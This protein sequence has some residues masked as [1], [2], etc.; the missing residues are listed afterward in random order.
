MQFTRYA[1]KPEGGRLWLVNPE[2]E[3]V[4]DLR[5]MQLL[6]FGNTISIEGG[7]FNDLLGEP[8]NGENASLPWALSWIEN[9]FIV[10]TNQTLLFELRRTIIKPLI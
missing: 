5:E 8:E 2:N 7:L 10:S 6:D 3:R 9:H 1:L 4:C